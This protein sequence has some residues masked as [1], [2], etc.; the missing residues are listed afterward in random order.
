MFARA[1]VITSLRACMLSAGVGKTTRVRSIVADMK[2]VAWASSLPQI[3]VNIFDSLYTLFPGDMTAEHWVAKGAAAVVE[4]LQRL[5][6]VPALLRSF[7]PD[8][9]RTARECC[10]TTR[11]FFFTY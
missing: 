9:D 3:L 10:G 1:I 8:I 7:F 5:S 11:A 6:V 4:Q 2:R